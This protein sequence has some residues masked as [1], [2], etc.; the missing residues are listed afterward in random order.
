MIKLFNNVFLTHSTVDNDFVKCLIGKDFNIFWNLLLAN[1]QSIKLECSNDSFVKVFVTFFSNTLIRG[2]DL[3]NIS[4]LLNLY[5]LEYKL[6][7]GKSLSINKAAISDIIIGYDLGDTLTVIPKS[8]YSFEIM[9]PN[10]L[11]TGETRDSLLKHVKWSCWSLLTQELY[12]FVQDIKRDIFSG[13]HV[14]GK[15]INLINYTSFENIIES[16]NDWRFVLDDRLITEFDID[17]AEE[18]ISYFKTFFPT[19]DDLIKIFNN[20][21]KAHRDEQ[22]IDSFREPIEMI[23]QDR[24][25]EVLI[26]DMLND[27][28]ITYASDS[29]GENLVCTFLSKV[30]QT[31]KS[32]ISNKEEVYKMFELRTDAV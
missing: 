32:T 18:S 3:N 22:G 17:T 30:Y 11:L 25:E 8:D 19:A 16:D 6:K 13:H 2:K 10:Y 26:R 31:Y 24:Y 21:A 15:D 9:L 29:L 4:N 12:M 1:N 14:T 20:H 27:F 23:Y 5:N 7:T 28:R